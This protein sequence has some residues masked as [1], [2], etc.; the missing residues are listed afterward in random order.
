MRQLNDMVEELKTEI[1]VQ[2]EI[3]A[4]QYASGDEM[5]IEK[6]LKNTFISL[7]HEVTNSSHSL[8]CLD[9][10]DYVVVTLLYCSHISSLLYKVKKKQKPHGS[11]DK[12]RSN[13]TETA[14]VGHAIQCVTNV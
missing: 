2:S 1:N 4:S 10:Q 9:N 8:C 3:L 7:C 6:E 13:I 11:K 12:R 5:S 14:T